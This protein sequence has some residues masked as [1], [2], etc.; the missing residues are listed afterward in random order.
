MPQ[1][2]REQNRVW[3]VER[4][5][6]LSAGRNGG[7]S[8][9]AA[10]EDFEEHLNIRPDLTVCDAYLWG[11]MKELSFRPSPASIG[12]MKKVLTHTSLNYCNKCVG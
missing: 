5:M 4:Y 6:K 10:R 2:R 12:E 1:H 9:A 11:I 7:T 8:L 3:C